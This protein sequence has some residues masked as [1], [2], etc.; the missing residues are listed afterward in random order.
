MSRRQGPF[1]VPFRRAVWFILGAIVVMTLGPLSLRPTTPFS[2]NFDRFAAY[3]VLGACFALAY[4]RRIYLL[5][6][7]LLA[8][9]GGLELAQNFVPNRDGRLEDFLVK[10]TGVIVGLIAA[11]LLQHALRRGFFRHRQS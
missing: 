10:A 3:L 8:T 11:C 7:T 9:T 6:L 2:G 5:A 4:P 1:A